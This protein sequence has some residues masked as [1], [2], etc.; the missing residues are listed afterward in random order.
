MSP[1]SRRLKGIASEACAAKDRHRLTR[2]RA[3][4]KVPAVPAQ[5]AHG[6]RPVRCCV[7]MESCCSRLISSAIGA[8]DTKLTAQTSMLGTLR[9]LVATQAERVA[10]WCRWASGQRRHREHQE[11]S[12]AGSER[13]WCFHGCKC[14][15]RLLSQ[16][17]L[18]M[19]RALHIDAVLLMSP[20]CV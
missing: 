14:T 8:L 6:A 10:A 15:G 16:K 19:R 13:P 1:V 12:W 5:L 20:V 3:E 4:I 17:C 9:Q 7:K 18:D 11:T 2:C